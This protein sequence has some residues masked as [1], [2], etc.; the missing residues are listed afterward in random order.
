[1]VLELLE[2]LI[3]R[4]GRTIEYA[5]TGQSSFNLTTSEFSTA[6]IIGS[7]VQARMALDEVR[8]QLDQ[9]FGI[10][11]TWPVLLEL[12]Q[13][14]A[15]GWKAEAYNSEGNMGRYTLQEMGDKRAHQVM[16]IPGL[17]RPRFC[18]LLAH[19]LVHAFQRE[20][21]ILVSNQGLREG[22]A[23]W[24]EYRFLI[25]TAPKEAEKLL[26]IRHFTF[27]KAIHA[28]LDYEKQHGV[29]ATMAWLGAQR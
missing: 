1:M 7:S 18:A 2:Q 22:M 14:P 3:N 21:G 6:A 10:R 26:K 17:P 15:L 4:V 13:P 16:I 5:L 8:E 19:E 12:K 28:V 11:L 25:R 9:E 24:V 29:A 23:R 27:G 20:K